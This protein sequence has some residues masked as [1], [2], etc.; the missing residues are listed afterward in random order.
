MLIYLNPEML[1]QPFLLEVQ[2]NSRR[3]LL[4]ETHLLPCNHFVIFSQSKKVQINKDHRMCIYIITKH[5]KLRFMTTFSKVYMASSQE[6]SRKTIHKLSSIHLQNSYHHVNRII[7]DNHKMF[8][9]KYVKFKQQ[10]SQE[11]DGKGVSGRRGVRNNILHAHF[12][13]KV[14]KYRSKCTPVAT[15]SMHVSCKIN[16]VRKL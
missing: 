9:K 4:N 14:K 2:G 15:W 12:I 16:K 10:N 7:Q 6:K 11:T 13:V 5:L 8:R 3:L 1:P